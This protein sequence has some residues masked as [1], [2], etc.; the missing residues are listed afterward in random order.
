MR[1]APRVRYAAASSGQSASTTVDRT[2]ASGSNTNGSARMATSSGIG[3]SP[4]SDV[5][6]AASDC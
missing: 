6:W 4:E 3:S 2:G 5:T 1:R